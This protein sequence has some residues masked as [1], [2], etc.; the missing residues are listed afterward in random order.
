MGLSCQRNGL[1]IRDLRK[2]SS[3]IFRKYQ[4]HIGMR[5]CFI[6]NV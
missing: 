6:E 1:E 2:R 3:N 5:K 4:A